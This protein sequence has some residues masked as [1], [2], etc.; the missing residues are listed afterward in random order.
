MLKNIYQNRLSKKIL[1][2]PLY[3]WISFILSAVLFIFYPQVD[4][5]ISDLFYNGRVFPANKTTIEQLL[6]HSVRFL[7]I[8]FALFSITVFLYN[9]FTKKK[10]LNINAKVILYIILTLSIAPGLIVNAILKDNWGRARPNQT[11]HFGNTKEFTPA[12]IPSNQ[13][14]YS[15]SSG[16]AAAAFSLMGFALLAKNRKKMW[17]TLAIT[18]GVNVSIARV[19]A[20][21]HFFSDVLTSFFIVY[22]TT[23]ILY[24][25]ILKE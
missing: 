25:I 3:I 24:G 17:M 13:G 22:I 21:G 19:A 1:F 23:H 15:F 7:I 10:I 18:Y 11:I 16:H 12:F 8:I 4:I 2:N 20:G 6:Y 9:K 5:F 14:G